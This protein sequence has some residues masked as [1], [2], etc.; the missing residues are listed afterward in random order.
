M[1]G[2]LGRILVE[3]SK[4]DSS[5]MTRRSLLIGG[6]DAIAAIALKHRNRSETVEAK[7]SAPKEVRIVQFSDTGKREDVATLP[8]V[9]KTELVWKQ[10]LSPAS[11]EVTRHAATEHPFSGE[12][13]NNT[14]HK[15]RGD[16]HPHAATTV[17][18]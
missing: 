6:G 13:W 18:E 16:L 4:N 2:Q 12:Y 15:Y 5:R 11:F 7:G 17:S 14:T 9:V 8:P 1:M 3:R 10:Q